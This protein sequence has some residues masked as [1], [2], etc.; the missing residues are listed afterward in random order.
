MLPRLELA[1]DKPR[2]DA[3]YVLSGGAVCDDVA[4]M[5]ELIL[6]LGIQLPGVIGPD[7]GQYAR[8]VF[9]P[10]AY[11]TNVVLCN[12]P[13]AH[14]TESTIVQKENV[15]LLALDGENV[16]PPCDKVYSER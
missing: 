1:A 9:C 11:F 14:I 2:S 15:Y 6:N 3:M 16:R 5:A 10:L 12:I 4:Y 13:C 7:D 8:M